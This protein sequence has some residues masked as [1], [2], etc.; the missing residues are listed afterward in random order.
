MNRTLTKILLLAAAAGALL[1]SSCNAVSGLGKDLQ[2][3]S[4]AVRHG[5]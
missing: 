1:L 5:H 3:A 4:D 2:H